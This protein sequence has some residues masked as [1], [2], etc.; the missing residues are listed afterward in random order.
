MK[1]QFKT[2]FTCCKGS[3]E[4]NT[5]KTENISYKCYFIKG[6]PKPADGEIVYAMFRRLSDDSVL[7]LMYLPEWS[8]V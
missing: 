3:L 1:T 7:L 2:A 8:G 5:F 4:G 6:R